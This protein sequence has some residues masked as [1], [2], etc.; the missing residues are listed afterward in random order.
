MQTV[1]KQMESQNQWQQLAEER[2]ATI[3]DLEPVVER[4]RADE[5]YLKERHF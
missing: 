1:H 2:A 4:A 5:F 3:A